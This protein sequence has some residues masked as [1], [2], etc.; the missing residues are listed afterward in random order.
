MY[1]PLYFI[2]REKNNLL[3][4]NV[5]LPLVSQISHSTNKTKTKQKKIILGVKLLIIKINLYFYIFTF[6]FNALI[7]FHSTRS[8][9]S[10]YS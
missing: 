9:P 10:Q 3:S 8:I 6:F 4:L 7:K 5:A 1:H 2:L